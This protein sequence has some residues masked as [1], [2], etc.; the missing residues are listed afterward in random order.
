MKIS[1]PLLALLLSAAFLTAFKQSF[2]LKASMERGKGVYQTYC[3]SC[4]MMEGE[5]VD[6]VFPPL[7]KNLNL[8]AKEKMVQVVLKGMRGPV[9][10]NNKVY[11]GEMAP[12]SISDE[13][14]ADVLNYIR[15][16][17]GNKAKAILPAEVQPA[18][19]AVVKDLKPY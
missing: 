12:V 15:N 3:M 4:H 5:G 7:A 2:D 17:W 18:L 16:T 8:T 6:G 9:K 10:V 13:E 14:T 19:K 11:D 1:Y